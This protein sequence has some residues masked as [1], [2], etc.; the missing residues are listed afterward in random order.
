EIA[1][2]RALG[3]TRP[4]AVGLILRETSILVVV[5]LTGGLGA[6]LVLGR[7]L[8]PFLHGV[9]PRDPV[10]LAIALAA[11]AISG[12][13]ASWRAASRAARIDPMTTLRES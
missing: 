12:T 1:V 7:T 5:A 6:A 13:L 9:S 10:T 4:Q 8:E 2:R 11:V 3:S